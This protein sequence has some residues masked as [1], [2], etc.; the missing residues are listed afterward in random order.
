MLMQI[1]ML[2]LLGLLL[3]S[4]ASTTLVN[5]WRDAEI[6]PAPYQRILVI[7]ISDEEGTRRTFEDEFAARLASLGLT[8]TP[9]HRLLPDTGQADER[10]LLDAVRDSGAQGVLMTRVVR[11]ENR[12]EYVPGHMQFAPMPGYYGYYMNAWAFYQPPRMYRYQIA[13]LET[14]LW[15]A[16]SAALVWSGSTETF[17]PGNLQKEL[18]EL[19]GI[20]I[21]ALSK[22]GLIAVKNNP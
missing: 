3:V 17:R 2:P 13:L 6:Q 7:G 16:E 12:T 5:E 8:A 14:N 20:V 18:E 9:G 15:D 1:L 4:C 22:Q 11:M 21:G 10:T 19:S